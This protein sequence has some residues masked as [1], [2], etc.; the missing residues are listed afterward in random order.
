MELQGISSVR[1]RCLGIALA[2]L[3]LMLTATPIQAEDTRVEVLQRQLAE[4]DKV[5]LELLRRVETLEKQIGVP[6]AVRDSAE[7]SKSVA[8]N[9]TAS[10]PGS[11]IV[12]E[13]MAERALERSLSREGALL[14][15]TGV[16]E[17]EPSLTFTRQEDATSLFV[18]SGGLIVAGETEI[19]ANR[20]SADLGL[21]LGLPWDAQLELGLPYRRAEVETVTNVGFAPITTSGSSGGGL[22]DL[23]IG[24]AKSLLREGL[25]RP[26]LVGR[27]TWNTASGENRDNGVS[28][29][30]GFHELQASLTAIKRQDPVVFIA[31]LSYQH[32][33]EKNQIT[34]GP[35]IATNLGAAI[36]LS[37]ETSLR[38]SLSGAYQGETE[39]FGS[40]VDG[41]DQV[42]GSFIIGSST[43]LAPG[44]LLNGTLAFGLTD[45]ADDM[46][47]LFSL[48][49]RFNTPLF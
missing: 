29:G 1:W 19:N 20:F 4:R 13:R 14:L 32:S 41:S 46:S 3:A 10:A 9:K 11:V 31:G 34:P 47:I 15:P 21:R 37:P 5:M 24:L 28:L 22:G 38:F 7:A 35:V 40:D 16:L 45:D 44:V 42:I 27:F 12:T 2:G 30:G 18:T 8:V 26:D 39:L 23:R 49:I 25:W 6:R 43:L 36:A 48:P 33:L 17:V